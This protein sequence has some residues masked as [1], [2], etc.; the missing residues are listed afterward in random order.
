MRNSEHSEEIM[1]ILGN[2][3]EYSQTALNRIH[4]AES[5]SSMFQFDLHVISKFALEFFSGMGKTM[6]CENNDGDKDMMEN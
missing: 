6:N 3:I 2:S 1:W 4:P 5:H